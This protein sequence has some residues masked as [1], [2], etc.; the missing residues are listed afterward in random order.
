MPA[1]MRHGRALG[2]AVAAV[3]YLCVVHFTVAPDQP[4]TAGALLAV[5][6]LGLIALG[7]ALTSRWKIPALLLWGA[8]V[9]ALGWN[10]ALIEAGFEWVYFLQH[11][12]VFLLLA[13]GFGRSLAPGAEPVVSRFARISHGTLAPVVARYTRRVTLAWALFFVALPAVSAL[14]FWSG[15]IASWS[16]FI[17]FGT[18]LLIGLMFGAE[19]VMRHIV[20]PKAYRTGLVES[21]RAFLHASRGAR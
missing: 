17:N 6:P 18:P 7:M 5:G 20:L 15:Q 1:A 8:T 10:W 11:C 19:F 2:L 16:V 3:L 13:A 12:G 4:S 21:I 14:L 9:A